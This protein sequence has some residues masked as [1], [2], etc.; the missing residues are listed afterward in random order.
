MHREFLRALPGTRAMMTNLDKWRDAP[1]SRF[2]VIKV[3]GAIIEEQIDD[4]VTA[5]SFLYRVGLFPIVLHGAGPQLN[6][7]MADN[8]IEPEYHEGKRI[9]HPDVLRVALPVFAQQN[10]KLCAALEAKGVRARPIFNQ[11]FESDYLDKDLY[12][13]VGKVTGVNTTPIDNAIEAG[14][15]PIVC[16]IG[17]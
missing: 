7:A 1:N 15:L 6:A 2:A 17:T 5:L 9:T 10:A 8:N 16:S 3:G 13:L 14:C 4:L 12:G 11:V